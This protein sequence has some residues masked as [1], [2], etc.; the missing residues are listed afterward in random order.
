MSGTSDLA[1]NGLS[2]HK[3]GWDEAW[4]ALAA[5]G[6]D[7]NEG[8]ML[9][10]I[11]DADVPGGRRYYF[12]NHSLVELRMSDDPGYDGKTKYVI[13][14]PSVCIPCTEGRCE[15]CDTCGSDWSCRCPCCKTHRITV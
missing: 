12:K 5:T 3:S 10:Q 1:E 11:E 6:R 14:P 15:I 4:A 8:W 2:C 7:I 9:M 13:L